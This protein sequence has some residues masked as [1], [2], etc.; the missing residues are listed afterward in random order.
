MNRQKVIR[1][2]K[3]ANIL[4]AECPDCGEEFLLAKAT[5]FDAAGPLPEAASAY[6]T[7]RQS[8]FKDRAERLTLEIAKLKKR[9][10]SAT[11]ISERCTISTGL[12]FILEKLALGWA[13]FPHRPQ[14]CR[15]LYEPIDYIAFDGL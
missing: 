14:D 10:L 1:D 9:K 6:V 3:K 2:L 12:G 11:V 7:Q 4:M 8:E 5:L 15:P 13:E